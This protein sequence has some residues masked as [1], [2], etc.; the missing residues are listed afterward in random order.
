ME[1][2]YLQMNKQNTQRDM[3]HGDTESSIS[4][5]APILKI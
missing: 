1:Y 4:S 2:N 5:F 3:E